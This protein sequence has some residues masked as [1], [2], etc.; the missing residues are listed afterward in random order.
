MYSGYKLTA[1]IGDV[2]T[3]LNVPSKNIMV[4]VFVYRT[5]EL[6]FAGRRTLQIIT[7]IVLM[8]LDGHLTITDPL[9]LTGEW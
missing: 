5:L 7:G 4:N 8:T 9:Q 1:N 6:E 2:P 3:F